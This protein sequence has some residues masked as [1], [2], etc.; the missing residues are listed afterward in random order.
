MKKITVNKSDEVSVIVEKMIEAEDSEIT[1]NIPRF[2]HIGESLSNFYLLKREADALGKK[3]SVESV[4]D[5]VIELAEMGGLIGANPFFAKNKRQFSDILAPRVGGKSLMPKSRV[6]KLIKKPAE[7]DIP[8]A[9]DDKANDFFDSGYAP[10][11]DVSI[12]PKLPSSSLFFSKLPKISLPSFSAPKISFNR[13]WIWSFAILIFFI[14]ASFAAA[15]ILPRAEIKIIPKKQEWAYNDAIMAEKSAVL[16]TRIMSIASQVFSETGNF[17]KKFPATG[18]RQVERPATGI[19]TVFNS[20]SSDAQQLVE[21]TRFMAP[22]G[23]LF[24]L[25]KT[26]TVPGAKIVDG[27]IIP[28]SIDAEVAADSAGPDYNIEPVKLF[29]IP[30]FK[31]SPKYQSF[32]GESA[33]SM[34]G[35]FIGEVAYPTSDDIAKAK[36]KSAVDLESDLNT[37]LFAQIPKEFKILDGARSYKTLSQKVDENTDADGNFSVFTEGKS[38]VISFKE[39]DAQELLKKKA[40]GENKENFEVRNFDLEYELARADFDKGKITFPVKFKAELARKMDAEAVKNQIVNKTETELK[41]MIFALPGLESATISL[42]PFWVKRV[43]QAL[44]KIKVTVE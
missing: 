34:S 40:L 7:I 10:R 33:K 25:T 32:Y 16:D 14:G 20:Y 3:I 6:G 29:T 31:G 19:I 18:K 2:S 8:T 30:G 4:D 36:A 17:S 37:K 26:I 15:K 24:R 23:L 28:S 39:K 21:K 1:L 43:P 42:W 12:Q 22:N 27:K 5:K 11:K 9:K 41:T 44:D 38:S 35:G 13:H